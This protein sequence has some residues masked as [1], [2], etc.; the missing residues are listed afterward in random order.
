MKKIVL[1]ASAVLLTVTTVVAQT[2]CEKKVVYH[3]ESQEMIS[4]AGDVG[5]TKTDVADVEVSK[6]S[7][8]VNIEG[9][10]TKLKGTVKEIDCAWKKP[11][12]DGKAVYKVTFAKDDGEMS[13]GT[14]TVE[15]KEGKI[16]LLFEITAMNGRKLRALVNRYAEQ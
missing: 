16:T 1:F 7:V 15:A 9:K 4:E 3:S 14:L 5:D 8:I 6:E 2:P 10:G 12:V 11:Y 13:D